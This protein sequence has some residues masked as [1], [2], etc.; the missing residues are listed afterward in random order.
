MAF[1]PVDR[2]PSLSGRV[3]ALGR[4]AARYAVAVH[5][6]PMVDLDGAYTAVGRSVVDRALASEVQSSSGTC[7]WATRTT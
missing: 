6:G 3:E 1:V 4:P 5:D 7:R 2:V